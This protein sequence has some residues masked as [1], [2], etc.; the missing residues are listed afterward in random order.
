[1]P[2]LS[3]RPCKVSSIAI[4]NRPKTSCLTAS[5]SEPK[6]Y[7]KSLL[8]SRERQRMSTVDSFKIKR[9]QIELKSKDWEQKKIDLLTEGRLDGWN[10]SK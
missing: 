9:R 2:L 3:M 10:H 4:G 5:R 8:P 1:M 7:C 6:I